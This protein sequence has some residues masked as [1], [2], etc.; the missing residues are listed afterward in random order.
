MSIP[1]FKNGSQ[2]REDRG[3]LSLYYQTS[4]HRYSLGLEKGLRF[5][6]GSRSHPLVGVPWALAEP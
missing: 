5:H 4:A 6:G 1:K 2:G 3:A